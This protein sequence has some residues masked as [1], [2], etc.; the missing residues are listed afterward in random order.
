MVIDALR[1]QWAQGGRLAEEIG[2]IERWGGVWHRGNADSRRIAE[3]PGVGVL[4]ATAV[5]AAM[6]DPAAFR[7]GREFTVCLSLVPRHDGTGRRIRMLGISKRGN[8]YVRTLLIHGARS[9]LTNSKAPPEWAV[10]LAERRSFNVATVALANK[11][12]RTIWVLLAHDRAYQ[13]NFVSQ[14]DRLGSTD[15]GR[16]DE[17]NQEVAAERL[18][19]AR[20]GVMANKS[21]RDPP[22]LNLR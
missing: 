10:R 6:G 7:S 11:T 18:R 16:N 13:A 8:R 12:T 2:E 3:I 1:E 19:K 22:S 14:S 17:P 9:V 20:Q 15:G 5:I 4:T 21:D